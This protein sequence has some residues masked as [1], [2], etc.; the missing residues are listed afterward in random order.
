MEHFID[1]NNLKPKLGELVVVNLKNGRQMECFRTGGKDESNYIWADSIVG[2]I[3]DIE[4]V[5]WK[6]ANSK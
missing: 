1:I 5:S 4:V 6:Y 2:L 3:I